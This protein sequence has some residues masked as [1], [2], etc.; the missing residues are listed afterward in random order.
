MK[1]K[2]KYYAWIY[3]IAVAIA[4]IA[5]FWNPMSA[6]TTTT[7]LAI[8]GIVIGLANV[9]K[10]EAVEFLIAAVALIVASLSSRGLEKILF[11]GKFIP[12]I[13]MNLMAI[14]APAAV[15]VALK[16]LNKTA[17]NR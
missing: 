13:L 9:S 4:I 8:L 5:A 16:E 15:I 17:K 10:K 1:M 12:A 6:T 7:I 14:V 11:I 3:L 2:A